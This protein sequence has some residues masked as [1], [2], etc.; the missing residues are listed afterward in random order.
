MNYINF[1]RKE[2]ILLN[3]LLALKVF[4][5]SI[6]IIKIDNFPDYDMLGYE[7]EIKDYYFC[8]SW[9]FSDTYISAFNID[10]IVTKVFH[11]DDFREHSDW[12]DLE[13][14]END[15]QR[16]NEI[17][18]KDDE[19]FY[20]N[21][22]DPDFDEFKLKLLRE[23]L[24]DNNKKKFFYEGSFLGDGAS[25]DMMD[26]GIYSIIEILGIPAIPKPFYM[27]LLGESFVLQK[28][29]KN[30]LSF[31]LAY[32]ALE[33][34]VNTILGTEDE[35]G[36]FIDKLKQLFKTRFANINENLVYTSIINEYN[37]ITAKRNIIAHG[38]ESIVISDT[39]LNSVLLFVVTLI[40]SFKFNCLSFEQIS[41]KL[42]Y[43]I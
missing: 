4:N 25:I 16:L 23:K 42:E 26:H 36:R 40:F 3:M 13:Y 28:E 24:I 17:H 18:L 31:F 33:S 41:E 21:G 27:E 43:G 34:F 10:I 32:S 5:K 30:N 29:K 7:R 12:D 11:A 37:E 20:E 1:V 35:E 15:E 19:W 6:N 22:Y 9:N 38:R 8:N 14:L 2:N 39:E